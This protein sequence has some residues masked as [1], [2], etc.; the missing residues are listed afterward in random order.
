MS[1]FAP[2]LIIFYLFGLYSCDGNLDFH[3]NLKSPSPS[4]KLNTLESMKKRGVLRWGADVIGG[5]P[6]V[7]EDPKNPRNYI[8]FEMDIAKSIAKYIGV[9]QEL[10]IKTWDSLIPELQRKSFD[11]ALNGI[12]NTESRRKFVNYSVPYYVYSQQL[13][14]RKETMDIKTL[15]D[16]KGKSVATLSGTAAEDILRQR[17][18]IILSI[19]PEI[20]Y[21]YKDLVDGKVDAVLLDTPIA[22][23]YAL[24]NPKLKNVGKSFAKGHYVIAFRKEDIQFQKV[25]NEAIQKMISSG[26]LAAIFK[27]WNIMNSHQAELG[28]K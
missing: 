16:L 28:I 12:E 13:S 18:E 2:F 11:M 23:A 14:V 15:D 7:Y 8:G 3:Q 27:K 22:A 21:S 1:K 20:I 24:P 19:H 6:Y 17:P 5:I 4:V 26:E 10:V 25:V 9:Q